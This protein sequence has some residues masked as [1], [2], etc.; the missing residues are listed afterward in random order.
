FGA[1]AS[2]SHSSWA[3]RSKCR[4]S[5]SGRLTPAAVSALFVLAEVPFRRPDLYS[6]M[7]L[8]VRSTRGV[9]AP[10][11][12]FRWSSWRLSSPTA[13]FLDL[14]ARYLSAA[15]PSVSPPGWTF[16]CSICSSSAASAASAS[17]F[18]HSALKRRTCLPLASTVTNPHALRLVRWPGTFHARCRTFA[19]QLLP[20][21][22]ARCVVHG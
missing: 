2:T 14:A 3:R 4:S 10:N 16:G 22:A 1:A 7:R 19:I 6:L 18:V 12:A 11:A 5:A 9:S 8:A 20:P 13:F 21:A 15:W 17:S